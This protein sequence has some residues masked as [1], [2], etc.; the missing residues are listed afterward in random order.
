MILRAIYLT[1]R[2]YLITIILLILVYVIFVSFLQVNAKLVFLLTVIVQWLQP[3]IDKF[4]EMKREVELQGNSQPSTKQPAA[5]A[6][7]TDWGAILSKVKTP[8]LIIASVIL[9]LAIIIYA[10]LYIRLRGWL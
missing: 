3:F 2:H 5:T 4:R 6:Y 1:I 9:L 8:S 7:R 10:Y